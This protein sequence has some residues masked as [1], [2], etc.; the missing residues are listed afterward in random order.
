MILKNADTFIYDVSFANP[1]TVTAVI[2]IKLI[3]L[4]IKYYIQKSKEIVIVVKLTLTCIT[5]RQ[6]HILVSGM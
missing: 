1:P 5:V 2:T 3:L 6:G 4:T